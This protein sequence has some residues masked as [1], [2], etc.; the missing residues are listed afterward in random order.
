V[1]EAWYRNHSRQGLQVIGVHTPEYA[2]EHVPGQRAGR[3][4]ATRD[5]LPGALDNAYDSWNNYQNESWPADDLIDADV[6]HSPSRP[7]PA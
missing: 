4:Q 2:F 3:R 6:A 1:E 5:H 7:R